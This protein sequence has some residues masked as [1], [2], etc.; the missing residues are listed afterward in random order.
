MSQ[1]RTPNNANSTIRRRTWSGNGRPLTNTPPSWLIPVWPISTTWKYSDKWTRLRLLDLEVH[2][3]SSYDPK[4]YIY[5]ETTPEK[6]QFN[7]CFGIT[8]SAK[9]DFHNYLS[10]AE[11]SPV[12]ALWTSLLHKIIHCMHT[13]GRA[14]MDSIF[15]N[16]YV[17]PLPFKS[18]L[19]NK[20]NKM[21]GWTRLPRNNTIRYD[22][23]V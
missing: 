18:L 20:N 23:R 17:K 4:S 14:I 21:F 3:G 19:L 8:S 16:S 2:K 12:S 10:I 11:K 5:K 7:L 15:Q 6:I 9:F 1:G 13:E 22:R